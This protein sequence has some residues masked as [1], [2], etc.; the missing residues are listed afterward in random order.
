MRNKKYRM[1]QKLIKT[2]PE[3]IETT[4]KNYSGAP[5][6]DLYDTFRQCEYQ[7]KTIF[8]KNS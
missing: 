7:D 1:K 6:V 8:L 3:K 4:H 5:N 2:L